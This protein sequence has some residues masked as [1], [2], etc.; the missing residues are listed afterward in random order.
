M[1]K[2]TLIWI[3]LAVILLIVLNMVLFNTLSSSE[4]SEKNPIADD[5]SAA[6]EEP[7]QKTTLDSEEDL[8][9]EIGLILD[10]FE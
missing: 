9:N 10:T 7:E 6:G 5:N 4:G 3:A 1:K 8:F 2:Q